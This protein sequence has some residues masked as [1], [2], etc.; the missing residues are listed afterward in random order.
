MFVVLNPKVLISKSHNKEIILGV[1]ICRWNKSLLDIFEQ[2]GFSFT[3]KKSPLLMN[4]NFCYNI[5]TQLTC[6]YK[7]NISFR[8]ESSSVIKQ[9]KWITFKIP[10]IHLNE[11]YLFSL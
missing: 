7:Q 6:S 9:R 10:S 8:D 1:N 4:G 3:Q 2:V 11:K 5:R